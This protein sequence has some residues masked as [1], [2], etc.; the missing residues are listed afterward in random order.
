[1]STMIMIPRL[2][3]ESDTVYCYRVDYV[4]KNYNTTNQNIIEYRNII[5]QSKMQANMKFKKC[6]YDNKIHTKC[7]DS[8]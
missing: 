8:I 2:E 3:C 1:M 6:V 4:E 5:K 7:K